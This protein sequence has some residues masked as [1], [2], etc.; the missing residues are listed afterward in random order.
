MPVNL[1]YVQLKGKAG[2]CKIIAQSRIPFAI[3][4]VNPFIKEC[5]ILAAI[6]SQ[7]W[8]LQR[9]IDENCPNPGIIGNNLFPTNRISLRGN[10]CARNAASDRVIF[11]LKI[12]INVIFCRLMI[13]YFS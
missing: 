8:S 4:A 13:D 12:K 3:E 5:G 9:G 11:A 10:R 2:E 7:I 6:L 1:A